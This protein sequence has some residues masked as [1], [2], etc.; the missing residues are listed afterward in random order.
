MVPDPLLES[1]ADEDLLPRIAGGDAGAFGELFRRRRK[2]VYRFALHVTGAP[3]TAEDVV[4]DVFLAVMRD[5]ARYERGRA[6]VVAWLCGIARNCARQRLD[7]ERTCQ[8]MAGNGEPREAAEPAVHPDPVGDLARA[9]GIEALRRAILSLPL[10][11]REAVVL[12]DL[13]E[14]SYADAA[15]AIGCAVGTVRSRLSRGRD[16][17]ARKLLARDE[18]TEPLRIAGGRCFA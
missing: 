13:E 4:Q 17:L 10:H 5:A 6:R 15:E 8:G 3:S 7:R 9:E 16:L 18:D 1:I 11:Y 14:L 2:D 12:C